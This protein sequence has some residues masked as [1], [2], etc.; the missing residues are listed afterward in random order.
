MSIQ[1]IARALYSL[2]REVEKLEQ[3]VSAATGQRKAALADQL[4]KLRAEYRHM[5]DIL[6]GQKDGSSPRR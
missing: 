1:L 6:D 4:R 3:E 5:R 2:L